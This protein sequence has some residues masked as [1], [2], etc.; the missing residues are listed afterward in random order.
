MNL[1]ISVLLTF[2]LTLSVSS[3]AT[4]P[5]PTGAPP[6]SKR[7]TTY[8]IVRGTGLYNTASA[9]ASQVA[10]LATG[11]MVEPCSG[12]SLDCRTITEAGV[13]MTS[14]CVKVQSTGARGWVLRQT[15]GQ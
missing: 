11:T 9:G 13:V 3:C 1:W 14:C 15:L 4:G 10:F 5:V 7:A 8:K 12:D 2:L 6:P